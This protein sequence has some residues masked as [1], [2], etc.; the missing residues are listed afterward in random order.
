MGFLKFKFIL[1]LFLIG[2]L[3]S[4][5]SEQTSLEEERGNLD[6]NKEDSIKM[7]I[8]QQFQDSITGGITPQQIL[9][10]ANFSNEDEDYLDTFSYGYAQSLALA[11]QDLGKKQVDQEEFLEGFYKVATSSI[12]GLEILNATMSMEIHKGMAQ[13]FSI[14]ESLK[15]YENNKSFS[16]NFGLDAANKLRQLGFPL[17]AIHLPSFKRAL[18]EEVNITTAE[19]N[20]KKSAETLKNIGHYTLSTREKKHQDYLTQNAQRPEVT[21]TKTR[22]QYEILKKGTGKQPTIHTINTVH[23]E[24]R[25]IDGRLFDSSI[26]RGEPIVFKLDDMIEGWKEVL[27][28]MKEGG[29]WRVVVPPTS[30]Y[31][32]TSYG[33]V[34]PYSVLVFDIELLKVK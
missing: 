17:E 24:G 32:K 27:P 19:K 34:P 1:C 18:C 9:A 20:L 8:E 15:K 30:G 14:P 2:L 3:A 29:K 10:E 31:G 13:G 11:V 7:S 26:E 4:C 16:Y 23:F 6:I 22:V 25:M 12:G 28:L 21:E 5:T 33:I